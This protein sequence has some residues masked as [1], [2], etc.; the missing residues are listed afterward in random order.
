MNT[1]DTLRGGC[2]FVATLLGWSSTLASVLLGFRAIFSL[3]CF[4]VW[5]CRAYLLSFRPELT[6]VSLWLQMFRAE[7]KRC[8][9]FFHRI[10]P[11]EIYVVS[12]LPIRMA[13]SWSTP[14]SHS[15]FHEQG[16][17]PHKSSLKRLWAAWTH[18]LY[19][20]ATLLTTS[21]EGNLPWGQHAN[22]I[23]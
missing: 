1:A 4:V 2:S 9:L 13:C 14:F 19:L 11:R 7:D 23:L 8:L 5:H 17:H 12:L 16:Q 18:Q 20:R 3:I 22:S 6:C 10:L 15:W 21:H